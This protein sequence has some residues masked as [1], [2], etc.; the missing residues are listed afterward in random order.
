MAWKHEKQS[1]CKDISPA[2]KMTS[3]PFCAGVLLPITGASRNRPP[4]AI[5][6]YK[7]KRIDDMLKVTGTF[8]GTKES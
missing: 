5:T 6:A 4:R 8:C 2:D 7:S 3:S 1:S